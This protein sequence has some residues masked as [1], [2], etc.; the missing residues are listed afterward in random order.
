MAKQDLEYE[1]R[2]PR[3]RG[4]RA[5]DRDREAISTILGREHVVGRLTQDEFQERLDRCLRAKTYGE[6]DALVADLPHDEPASPPRRSFRPAPVMLVPVA[7]IALIAVSGGRIGFL[8]VPV[9]FFF[10]VRPLVWHS[11]GRRAAWGPPPLP[12]RSNQAPPF[13]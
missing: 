2:R 6:L 13:S 9:F 7:L 1:Y 8:V 4:L 12:P 3:D 11:R 10:F 5:S